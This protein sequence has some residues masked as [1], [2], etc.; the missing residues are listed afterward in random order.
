MANHELLKLTANQV[1][2][3][4]YD[5]A[6][7]AIGSCEA[8]GKHLAEGTDTL[9][10]Y[11]LS[12]KI[13]DRVEG[14]LVLPPITVG[15]SGHYDT[16]PFTITLG[17]D[18]ITQVIYDIIESVLRNGV[19]KI[20]LMNGHDGN[21]APIEIASRKIKEKYPDARIASLPAWWVTAGEIL[22]PDTF[23]VWNGMGHAG[24]G[25]SSIAYHLY[26][27]W[28]EKDLAECVIPD[29]LPKKVEIKWDFAE[30]TNTAQT[31][32]ATKATAEK[33]EKMTKAL[34]DCLVEEI[35]EL[36]KIG[37]DYTSTKSET[38]LK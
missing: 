3:A 14:L 37:W 33:G 34:V 27:Q 31:G 26:P 16:F 20:F 10:S 12:C 30:I 18:T 7:L 36:D 28:C 5:K 17:Y 38:K 23:E 15:Y 29:R 25:E 8:H 13:A 35:Q 21:I 6:I 24:E 22:P 19:N 32:D 11:M 1:K 4:N 2:N 9:V